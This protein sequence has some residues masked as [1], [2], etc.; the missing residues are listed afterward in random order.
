LLLKADMMNQASLG[1]TM[2]GDA[3]VPTRLV[4]V[5][6]G[7]AAREYAAA[8]VDEGA[9][10]TLIVPR[11]AQLRYAERK[12]LR[13]LGDRSV[14]VLYDRELQSIRTVGDESLCILADGSA[15]PADRV[16]RLDDADGSATRSP[17]AD[18]FAATSA[19]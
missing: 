17:L 19:A 5:G 3:A 7:A 1:K 16:L 8:L 6:A 15:Y 12:Q 9:T 18:D 2:R 14:E 4:I 11:G 13:R 10:V